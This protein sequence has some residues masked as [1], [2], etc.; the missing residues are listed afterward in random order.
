VAAAGVRDDAACLGKGV[1]V[2]VAKSKR[3]R[4]RRRNRLR[5]ALNRA[6]P[7]RNFLKAWPIEWWMRKWR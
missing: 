3:R 2:K 7:R 1:E 5:R 6:N 4:D